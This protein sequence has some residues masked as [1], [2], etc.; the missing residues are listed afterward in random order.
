MF[1]LPAMLY[2]GDD[3]Q[4]PKNQRIVNT[5]Q[6]LEDALALGWRVLHNPEEAE[7]ALRAH[8]EHLAAKQSLK[9]AVLKPKAPTRKK[10]ED[11]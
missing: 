3:I 6:D 1:D 9:E 11:D 4:H 10:K 8:K 5:F 7:E 2:K